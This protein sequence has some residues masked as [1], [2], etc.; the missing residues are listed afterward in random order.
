MNVVRFT[1]RLPFTAIISRSISLFVLPG[2][3]T[4]PVNSSYR[5]T[6]TDQRSMALSSTVRVREGKG[7]EEQESESK[8][9]IHDK[10]TRKCE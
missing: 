3:M 9:P 4:C 6:A 10:E 7:K 2:N 8:Y 1:R 5:Q